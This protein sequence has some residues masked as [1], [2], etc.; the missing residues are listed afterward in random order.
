MTLLLSTADLTQSQ[1]ANTLELQAN[2]PHLKNFPLQLLP[3]AVS[4][5][6]YIV[7]VSV[8]ILPVRET[9]FFF[10]WGRDVT[11]ITTFMKFTA[12]INVNLI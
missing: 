4:D 6:D 5:V 9:F 11:A 3:A 1:T 2:F 8:T 12:A 10:P 7:H